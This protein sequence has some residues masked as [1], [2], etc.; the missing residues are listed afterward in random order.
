M[1]KIKPALIPIDAVRLLVKKSLRL[2]KLSRPSIYFYIRKK[3]FPKPINFG[4]PRMWRRRQV[5]TWLDKLI[6]G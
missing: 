2:K 5:V 6:K 3:K 4:V 1:P